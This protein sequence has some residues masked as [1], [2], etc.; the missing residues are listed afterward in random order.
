MK[1]DAP[2]GQGSLYENAAGNI[3]IGLNNT[4]HTEALYEDLADR[5]PV[6]DRITIAKS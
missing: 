1:T 5:P 6:Y 4:G 2:H 3:G